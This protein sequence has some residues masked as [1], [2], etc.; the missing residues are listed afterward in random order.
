MPQESTQDSRYVVFVFMLPVSRLQMYDYCWKG[1]D[2]SIIIGLFENPELC[3]F[4]VLNLL[5][6]LAGHKVNKVDQVQTVYSLQG[7]RTDLC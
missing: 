7:L 3:R 1:S 5:M 2:F 6:H 4:S